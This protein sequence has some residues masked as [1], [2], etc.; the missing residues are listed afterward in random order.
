MFCH[1][2]G[3]KL[4]ENDQFCLQCGAKQNV[5]NK[6][7]F[8]A[9]AS[10][11]SG[12]ASSVEPITR[13]T[14]NMYAAEGNNP[15]APDRTMMRSVNGYRDEERAHALNELQRAYEWFSQK[16][17]AYDEYD[18]ISNR[19]P[20]MNRVGKRPLL[21]WGC[22]LTGGSFLLMLL[23]LNLTSSYRVSAN[24]GLIAVV[25]IG[26]LA[27][28]GMIA[29]F[30]IAEANRKK[31]I[32]IL[33]ERLE[34]LGQELTDHY[35]AFGRCSFGAE[36]SNP[37]IINR[38]MNLVNS[39]RADSIKEGINIMLSDLRMDQMAEMSRITAENVQ[40][41]AKNSAAA[42]RG[43]RTAAAFSAASFFLK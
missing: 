7:L 18:S 27:G 31:T 19:L 2:C 35:I 29:G 30:F 40:I 17:N 28:A 26:M 38:I 6:R 15:L 23:I 3:T 25:I 1:N 9:N 32:S 5:S 12:S 20:K 13:Q 37:M 10:T 24:G 43:A 41:I 16:Q 39:G 8:V 21:I 4:S 36:Y 42:A 33:H 22:I 34:H 11:W 14:N